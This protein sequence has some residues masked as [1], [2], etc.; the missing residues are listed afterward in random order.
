MHVGASAAC[1]PPLLLQAACCCPPLHAVSCCVLHPAVACGCLLPR[2]DMLLTTAAPISVHSCASYFLCFGRNP[3]P[4]RHPRAHLIPT[5]VR[6][7]APPGCLSAR[8][9]WRLRAAPPDLENPWHASPWQSTSAT[10][11]L[12]P[13]LLR[14]Q[15]ATCAVMG[16]LG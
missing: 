6:S 15:S 2:N 5:T 9:H 3:L 8:L 7:P 4:S 16:P 14:F 1:C 13:T 10:T 11:Q 12:P